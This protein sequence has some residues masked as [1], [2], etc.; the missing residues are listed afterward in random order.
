MGVSP[1]SYDPLLHNLLL[2]QHQLRF[3][4]LPSTRP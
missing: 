4:A 2:F 3:M 1:F